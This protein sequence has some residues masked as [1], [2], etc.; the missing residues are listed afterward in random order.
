MKKINKEDSKRTFLRGWLR[1]LRSVERAKKK[2]P[3]QEKNG[4][5]RF[6]DETTPVQNQVATFIE[7]ISIIKEYDSSILRRD[8]E[9]I[10]IPKYFDLY[11]NPEKS[12]LFISAATKLIARGKWKSYIFDYKKN[13]KHCLGLECLLGVALTAARQSNINFKDTMIQING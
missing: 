11:D 12:L 10:L 8:A 5:L 4:S 9:K 13:K 6:S 2:K 1:F 7:N 3:A